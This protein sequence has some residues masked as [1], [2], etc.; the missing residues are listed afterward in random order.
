MFYVM[1]IFKELFP[2][3]G[4]Y[5]GRMPYRFLRIAVYITVFA[6]MFTA[7]VYV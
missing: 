5:M 1:H 7:Y 2:E 6:G 4:F 3:T